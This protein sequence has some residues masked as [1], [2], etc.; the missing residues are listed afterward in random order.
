MSRRTRP[1]RVCGSCGLSSVSGRPPG[2]PYEYTLSMFT[3]RAPFALGGGQ[4]AA[5]QRREVLGPAVVLGVQRL[6]DGCRA[7]RRAGR[8]RGIRDVA[9]RHVDIAERLCIAA[10]RRS[11]TPVDD[12]HGE[13]AADECD[14]GGAADGTGAEDHVQVAGH[15]RP[16][17]VARA[18][19]STRKERPGA[20]AGSIRA[21]GWIIGNPV[22]S[23]V[24]LYTVQRCN[25]VRCVE[26]NRKRALP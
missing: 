5:L 20:S 14:G 9:R 17:A 11:T 23:L 4:H 3:K 21:A 7:L 25:T 18:E 19:S 26:M 6:V 24:T 12:A 2:R 8:E 13:A 1:L 15:A 16:F 10:E 22:V